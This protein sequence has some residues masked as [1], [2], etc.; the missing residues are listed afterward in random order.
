MKIRVK[1]QIISMV[2][3][4]LFSLNFVVMLPLFSEKT[5][6][7]NKLIILDSLDRDSLKS[8]GKVQFQ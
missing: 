4:L 3:L 6:N 5:E 8:S 2:V 7:H 1:S